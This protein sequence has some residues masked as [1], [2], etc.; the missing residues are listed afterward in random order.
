MFGRGGVE[1]RAQKSEV[2]ELYECRR[3]TRC[4]ELLNEVA[5]LGQIKIQPSD[6][7]W[8]DCSVQPRGGESGEMTGGNG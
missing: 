7:L 2:L 5:G 4:G 8:R 6:V 3:Q 1:E